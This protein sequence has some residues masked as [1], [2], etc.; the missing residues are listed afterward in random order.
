MSHPRHASPK[1]LRG[2]SLRLTNPREDMSGL[3]NTKNVYNFKVDI[4]YS[5]EEG[6]CS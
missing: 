3:P 6:L 5:R 2:H 1:Y 4:V